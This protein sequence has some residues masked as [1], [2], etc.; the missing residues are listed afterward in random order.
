MNFNSGP[1]GGGGGEA[2][3]NWQD[4]VGNFKS[5]SKPAK[6]VKNGELKA[7]FLTL[8]FAAVL[9]FI[10]LPAINLKAEEFYSYIATVLIFYTIVRVPLVVRNKLAGSAETPRGLKKTLPLLFPL[11]LLA[12]LVVIAAVGALLSVPLLRASAY[13]KLLTVDTGEFTEDV[14]AVSYNQ[15]PLLD[16]SSAQKLGDRKLGELADMVSQFEVSNI[17]TQINFKGRP[18]RVTPLNYG[19]LFKWLNNRQAGLPAYLVID[20]ITQNVDVV[21]LTDYEGNSAD[22]DAGGGMKISPSEPLFRNLSRLLRFKYPTYMFEK[23]DFELDEQGVPYWVASHKIKRIGLFSGADIGGVVLLNAITGESEYLEMDEV[24]SWV[25]NAYSADLIIEQFDYYGRYKNGFWN[26]MFG[27]RDVVMTT[28]G[29]NYIAMN[30]DVYMYTGITSVGRDESNTGFIW[31]NLRTK[32]TKYYQIPGAEEYSAMNS[33]RGV[34]QHLG[35]TPT[36]PLLLNIGD[37]PTYVLALKDNAD[38]V[39]K[40]AMVNYSSYQIVAEGDS[41]A[42]VERNYL[43][44]LKDRDLYHGEDPLP[45]TDDSGREIDTIV[46][47][48][49]IADLRTAVIEGTSM[50]YLRLEGE[51]TYYVIS[52]ARHPFVILLGVGN[53]VELRALV[54]EGATTLLEVTSIELVS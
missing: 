49:T 18:V 1:F 30:D 40:Y 50:Y 11:Y 44:L 24:P 17:Y 35:Y 27:Q 20:M 2:R 28:D 6:P 21:R 4:V 52:A 8:L 10:T 34:V 42:E 16:R 26:S 37:Q 47:S 43:Q 29:Y 15:I 46:A 33:A 32:N 19:D 31:T 12:A 3:P 5:R 14:G 9:F 54:P 39:K 7:F 45:E 36:F 25:D 51:D 13:Q 48:G 38:L 53:E 41:I 22:I 23:V